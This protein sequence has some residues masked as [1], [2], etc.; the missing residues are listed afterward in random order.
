MTIS[1]TPG[2]ACI[3]F[4]PAFINCSYNTK[5]HKL[6]QINPKC[7]SDLL[8]CILQ[9]VAI[10]FDESKNTSNMQTNKT[11]SVNAL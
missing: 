11:E 9:R 4:L 7:V 2:C 8:M 1:D 5:C 6:R 3:I 10:L